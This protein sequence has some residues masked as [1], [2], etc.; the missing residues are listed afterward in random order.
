ML[1]YAQ[2]YSSIVLVPG[3][4]DVMSKRDG[5]FL[6]STA[7][8]LRAGGLAFHTSNP[9]PCWKGLLCGPCPRPCR[10][11]QSSRVGRPWARAL[12]VEGEQGGEG[13]ASDGHQT[14]RGY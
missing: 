2:S 4:M 11:P 13:I 9:E 5:A 10:P 14:G 7:S 3:A 12:P 6:G 8:R 1:R